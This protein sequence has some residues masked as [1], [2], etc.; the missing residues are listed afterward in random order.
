MMV[1]DFVIAV[2]AHVN[3]LLLQFIYD[4]VIAVSDSDAMLM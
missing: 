4:L 3:A 2:W 1:S